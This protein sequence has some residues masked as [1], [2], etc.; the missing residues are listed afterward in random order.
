MHSKAK[1][2][3]KDESR[4]DEYTPIYSV[5]DLVNAYWSVDVPEELKEYILLY[6]SEVTGESVD[7]V[8]E[9]L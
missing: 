1:N 9:M 7:A 3:R 8:M 5:Q 4:M 2:K 6:M